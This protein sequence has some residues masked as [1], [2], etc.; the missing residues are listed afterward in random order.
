MDI[1]VSTRAKQDL[2][3]V[4]EYIAADNKDEAVKFMD[5]LDSAIRKLSNFP[6]M[7]CRPK[8]KTLRAKGYRFLVVG[9]YLIFYR[10]G[11]KVMVSAVIHGARSYVNLL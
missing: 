11:K 3:A 6:E 7:G 9:S 8:H 10:I 5:K 4:F 1:V 2:K